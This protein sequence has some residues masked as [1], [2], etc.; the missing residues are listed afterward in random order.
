MAQARRNVIKRATQPFSLVLDADTKIPNQFLTESLQKFSEG[1]LACTL[2][3]FPDTQGHPP[4][5]AS[6]W[7]TTKLREIYDYH[8]YVQNYKVIYEKTENVQGNTFYT[9]KNPFLCECKHIW[10]K[11]KPSELYVFQNLKAIHMR[12]QYYEKS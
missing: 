2:S 9:I 5:G 3:Y 4:F 11:L 1:Y 8:V 10:P 12:K 7:V 6:F